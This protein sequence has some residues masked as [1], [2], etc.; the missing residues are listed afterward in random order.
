MVSDT[1]VGLDDEDRALWKAIGA[2]AVDASELSK[3]EL[4]LAVEQMADQLA[5]HQEWAR[6]EVAKL[7]NR[8]TDAERKA[9]GKLAQERST[10]LGKYVAMG[11]Q[12]RCDVLG[13]A[14]R[15][16]VLIYEHWEDLAEE[17]PNGALGVSTRR[18]STAKYNPSRFKRDLEARAPDDLLNSKG[19]IPWASI[20]RAMMAVADLSGGEPEQRNG[21]KHIAGGVFEYHE[22]RVPD[23]TA[24][25]QYKVLVES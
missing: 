10:T 3:D 13:K 25:R 16:A 14:D 19:S 18:N 24:D 5:E 1:K 21:R 8:V 17:L 22:H 2:G 12:N 6:K 11:E 4:V 15:L 20:H 7:H 23:N 9:D